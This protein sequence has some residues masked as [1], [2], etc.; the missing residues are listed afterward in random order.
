MRLIEWIL[1]VTDILSGVT[2]DYAMKKQPTVSVIIPIYNAE[3]YL[4]KCLDSVVN[5][6]YGS[7]DILLIDDGSTD[8][9][10]GIV[11]EYA[12]RDSRIQAFHKPNGGLGSSHN[13]GLDHMRGDYVT[14]VDNDDWIEANYV[15]FLLKQLEDHQL[16]YSSC[17]GYDFDETSGQKVFIGSHEDRIFTP[18]E[19]VTDI[20]DKHAFT[21]EALTKKMYRKE[22][23][24]DIRLQNDRN[25]QD[26]QVFFRIVSRCSKIGYFAEP[27]YNYLIRQGSI[28]HCGYRDYSVQQV[29]AYADNLELVKT[30]FPESLKWMEHNI[31]SVSMSNYMKLVIEHKV[32]QYPEDVEYYKSNFRKYKPVVN[33]EKS[34][35]FLWGCWK[36]YHINPKWLDEA[37]LNNKQQI[38]GI[39]NAKI[40]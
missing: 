29:L 20:L 38:A 26:T 8:S 27:L 28:T 11:D 17:A 19:A 16:D 12:K 18:E 30:R 2:G 37:I 22:I 15:S 9:S 31:L 13:F 5:Q 40:D 3:K 10:P 32:D 23:F 35:F 24:Q 36:L 33:G 34:K 4:R 1:C 14:F 7:L 39:V 6:D 25:Y 21:M